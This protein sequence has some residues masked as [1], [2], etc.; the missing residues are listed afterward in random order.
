MAKNQK[1]TSPL[2]AAAGL[3]CSD[4]VLVV[5]GKYHGG[6]GTPQRPSSGTYVEP[7]FVEWLAG[8]AEARKVPGTSTTGF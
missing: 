4:L 2:I 8:T 3:L 7:R 5:R 6:S 1:F